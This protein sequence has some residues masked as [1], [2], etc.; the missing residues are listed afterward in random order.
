MSYKQLQKHYTFTLPA[1][2][3]LR[4]STRE[5]MVDFLYLEVLHFGGSSWW[6]LLRFRPCLTF[7]DLLS[8]ILWRSDL[9]RLWPKPT[10]S[11]RDWRVFDDFANGSQHQINA[12]ISTFFLRWKKRWETTC[13]NNHVQIA[14]KYR[15]QY[16][17]V[18]NRWNCV[19]VSTGLVNTLKCNDL[20]KKVIRD[21]PDLEF[22]ILTSK[23]LLQLFE[24]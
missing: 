4:W 12:D 8:T 14:L 16:F 22:K 21:P 17:N 19:E 13:R 1:S 7:L 6:L 23:T 20:N 11:L 9:W 3:W 5:G 2:T 18:K 24:N 15:R 10:R